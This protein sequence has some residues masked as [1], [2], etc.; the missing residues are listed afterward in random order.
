M[1]SSPLLDVPPFVNIFTIGK[2]LLVVGQSAGNQSIKRVA[3]SIISELKKMMKLGNR[4]RR[5]RSFLDKRRD[6]RFYHEFVNDW[7][8]ATPRS[9]RM[10]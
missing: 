2:V 3:A 5:R 8:S 4:F 1:K 7:G 6:A 9:F 10:V